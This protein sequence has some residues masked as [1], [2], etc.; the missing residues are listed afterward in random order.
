MLKFWWVW[1]RDRAV[2][3]TRPLIVFSVT[4]ELKPKKDLS[5]T[6]EYDLLTSL[7]RWA[8]NLLGKNHP[9]WS[10]VFTARYERNLLTEMGGG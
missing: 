9:P 8:Q 3:G 5:M 6:I 7:F 10:A 2:Y 1:N 4:Y